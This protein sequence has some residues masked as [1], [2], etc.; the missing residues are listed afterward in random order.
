MWFMLYMCYMPYTLPF[1][2]PLSATG[3]CVGCLCGARCVV[4]VAISSTCR[5]GTEH[6]MSAPLAVDITV[7]LAECLFDLLL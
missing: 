2:L 6:G 4:M 7:W 5:S 3:P 1:L